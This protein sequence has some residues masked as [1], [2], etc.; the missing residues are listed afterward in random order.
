[1]TSL[2][3]NVVNLICEW[4]ADDEQEWM[5]FFCPKTHK[6]SYKFNRACKNFIEKGDV[7]LH[8]RLDSYLIEGIVNV[9]FINLGDTFNI[10]FKGI[11]FQYGGEF[12]MYIEFDSENVESKQDKYIYRSMIHFSAM[13]YGGMM[14]NYEGRTTN[15]YLNGTNFGIVVDAHY[16][17]DIEEVSLF[18]EKY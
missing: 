4:A 8:N 12:S 2:P 11:L 5:P 9:T 10:N 15:L 16:E 13:S 17:H 18:V 1:M 6:L 3:V 7:I 14:Y